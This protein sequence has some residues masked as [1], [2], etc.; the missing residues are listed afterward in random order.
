ML[1]K[2]TICSKILNSLK[3]KFFLIG[4]I[5]CTVIFAVSFYCTSRNEEFYNKDIAKVIQINIINS[6]ISDM[7]GKSESIKK[8]KIE[9][10]IMN[11]KYKNQKIKLENVTSYSEVNDLNL[12]VNDEIFVSVYKNKEGQISAK[13]LDFKRDKYILRIAMVFVVFMLIVGGYKGLRSLVSVTINV[14]ILVILVE[15]FS[16]G[17][18]LTLLSI[19]ASVLFIL[20]SILIVC[21][22][23]RKT[24]SS[25]VSTFICTFVTMLIAILIIK[26][27]NWSGVHFEEM[28]FLTHPPESIF[29]IELLIGT[30]GGIMDI[31]ISISASLNEIYNKNL[32][33][34]KKELIASGKEVGKDIMGT[35]TNTLVFAYVSGSIPIIL[36]LMSNG[37]SISY[38]ININLSLEIIRA[39]VGSIGIVLSI[40]ISIYTSTAF[41]KDWRF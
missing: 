26:M 16:H 28:E 27:R 31:A 19:I 13:L 18:N 41:L 3:N 12:K 21:G 11:G 25:I 38:I 37:Y 36:L 4:L 40:P 32:D 30:L 14:F 24:L 10:V 17:A 7:N 34:D 6:K 9:A 39:L 20:L 1:I 23:S 35:M 8:Q 22:V 2:Q 33:I 15:L 29:I 5:I